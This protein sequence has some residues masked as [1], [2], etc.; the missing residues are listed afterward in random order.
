MNS[1]KKRAVFVA[2]LMTYLAIGAFAQGLNRQGT[3]SVS[4]NPL[5]VVLGLI[6][7]EIEYRIFPEVSAYLFCEGLVFDYAIKRSDHPDVVIEVGPRYHF[8]STQK[9][10]GTFDVNLGGSFGCTWSANYPGNTGFKLNATVGL[11]YLF[12]NPSYVAAKG[13]LTYSFSNSSVF[14]GFEG[15]IGIILN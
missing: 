5:K 13:I 11:K 12:F 15:Q 3:L 8:L 1:H 7:L 14:P 4:V 2:V 10:S 9:Q 6:N